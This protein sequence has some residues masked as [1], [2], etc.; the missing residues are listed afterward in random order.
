[1]KKLLSA[2]LALLLALTALLPALA[3][4]AAAP[5]YVRITVKDYGDVY[6]EVYPDTA[7]ITVEN[8][9]TLVGER[10][11]DGLTFHRIISGFM[12]QGGDPQGN[13]TG[14]SGRQIKGEFSQNGVE[15]PLKH[16]RGVLSMARSQMMDSASSQFFIMH[17]DAPH[18]D[19]SYAAFGRVLSGLWV[20]D[21]ICQ[22][23]PVQDGNGTVAQESKPVIESIREVEKAEAEAARATEEENGRAGTRYQDPMT[24]LSFPVPEG[25]NRTRD[26]NGKV[27]FAHDG[28][29]K[30]MIL[31]YDQW[32]GIP[33]TGRQQ[34]AAQN[35]KKEDLDTTT[36]KKDALAGLVGVDAADFREETRSG[37]LFYAAGKDGVEYAVGAANGVIYLFAFNGTPADPGY[38]DVQAILDQLTVE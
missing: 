19:G 15:N 10:F 23:T 17:A 21:K 37:I 2:W 6:A 36:Y 18:L 1:M 38:A 13:G 32:S 8:F 11:Y 22:V 9:M 14:G 12:I 29:E 34:L 16:E 4:E 33:E 7:P 26:E 25:W 27:L 30:L 3:E 24:P 35:I 20:V 5:R 28:D 31:R